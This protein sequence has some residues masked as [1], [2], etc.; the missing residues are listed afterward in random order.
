MPAASRSPQPLATSVALEGA[1]GLVVPTRPRASAPGCCPSLVVELLVDDELAAVDAALVVAEGEVG[2]DAVEEA[3]EDAGPEGVVGT[4]ADDG[5]ADLLVGHA[6]DALDGHEGVPVGAVV[7]A[8]G[9]RRTAALGRRRR[10]VVVI[11]GVA[12]RRRDAAR[13]RRG[14]LASSDHPRSRASC[15]AIHLVIAWL[16][17]GGC[18]RC[19]PVDR[20][21]RRNDMTSTLRASEGRRSPACTGGC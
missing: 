6:G 11:V 20:I 15:D 9:R 14:S 2:V 19:L 7:L 5:V 12:A 17:H 10:G 1:E 8:L 21:D 3:V 16:S 4:R 13:R 18:G